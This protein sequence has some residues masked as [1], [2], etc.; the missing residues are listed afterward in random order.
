MQDKLEKFVMY[1]FKSPLLPVE[2]LEEGVKKY[3]NDNFSRL[4]TLNIFSEFSFYLFQANISFSY[5]TK[6]SNNFWFSGVFSGN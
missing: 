1:D 6:T 4:M 5:P 3:V 2:T